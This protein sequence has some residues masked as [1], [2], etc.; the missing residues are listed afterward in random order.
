MLDVIEKIFSTNFVG[1]TSGAEVR[2]SPSDERRKTNST[3]VA[4]FRTRRMTHLCSHRYAS[5]TQGCMFIM[6][7]VV[8][9]VCAQAHVNLLAISGLYRFMRKVSVFNSTRLRVIATQRCA[10]RR[11]LVG[12]GEGP[13]VRGLVFIR[14]LFHSRR[15]LRV[16]QAT[17]LTA[18]KR[19]RRPPRKG[20]VS[21][22]RC[23]AFSKH[24]AGAAGSFILKREIW[25]LQ[26]ELGALTRR[27]LQ[28]DTMRSDEQKNLATARAD[29]EQ[30]ISEVQSACD[31]LREH[32]EASFG[33][34][35]HPRSSKLQAQDLRSLKCSR[36]PN[37]LFPRG[38][39]WMRTRF[40][41]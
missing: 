39:V 31:I 14:D 28:T 7:K 38:G 16:M 4:F 5:C 30:D 25:A 26:S 1:G 35:L 27:H 22:P 11:S 8:R 19:H 21:K 2:A 33:Q 34:Q 29:F 12:A 17:Y 3:R 41:G 15:E 24:K 9:I 36:S 23:E 13:F 6:H 20:R 40:S 32:C 18:I 10:K 37:I